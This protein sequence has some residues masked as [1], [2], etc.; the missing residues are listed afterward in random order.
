MGWGIN[1]YQDA[2]GYVRC[3]DADFKTGPDDYEGYPPCSYDLIY[4]GVEESHSEI[5]MARDE[6][7]LHDARARAWEAFEDAK[8][9]WDRLTEEEQWEIHGVWMA[10]KRQEVKELVV[11][12]NARKAK[13]EEIEKF[14]TKYGPRLKK[15]GGDIMW[16]EDLL[17]KKRAKLAEAR[18]PLDTLEAEYAAI[19]R[20]DVMKR[21][22]QRLVHEEKDWARK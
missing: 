14:N 9:G 1:I 18:E 11:D 6:G 12:S 17:V 15:L 4:E 20:P 19:V 3:D 8:C 2:N 7:S 16:L 21:E 22:I 10:N 5:D 13:A